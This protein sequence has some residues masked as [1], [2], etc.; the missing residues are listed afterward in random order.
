MAKLKVADIL[1]ETGKGTNDAAPS[2][3][4]PSKTSS[5]RKATT[6]RAGANKPSPYETDL[7]AKLRDK[8]QFNVGMIPVFIAD[9]FAEQASKAGMNKREYFYH[10]LREQGGNIPAYEDM[11]G[12][13]L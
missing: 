8:T 12:R 9:I 5:A 10:L 11:D 2:N 4:A 1:S 3:P 6:V 13:K 7:R